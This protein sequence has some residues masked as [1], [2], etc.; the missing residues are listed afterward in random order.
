MGLVAF[1]YTD[2]LTDLASEWWTQPE[3]SYGLL[4][5]PFALYV[6]YLQKDETLALVARP[7][8]SGLLLIAFA[9]IVLITGKLASEFFLTRIS[10]VLLLSGL[11]WTFWGWARF[12]SLAFPLILLLT[13]VPPPVIVYNAAAAPLQLLAS[14][15]AADLAQF[16]GVSIYR[17][18]NIIQL[19]TTSLG[20]AEACSG[21]HSLSALIV[22]SLLLG[23]LEN[24]PL[25]ARIA[26]V[27]LSVPL[28][29]AVNVLRVT[30]TAI[31]ADYR[32]ELALGYYH[33]FSGWLV[34][35]LGFALLWLV[36][37]LIFR[38]GGHPS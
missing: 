20:V 18:G 34:F 32:P 13:M 26:V 28:A 17:D 7:A 4:I 11:V 15:I 1:L 12:R 5:P 8:S 27:V 37:K 3:A 38:F 14:K 6:A 19:A 35:V 16:V 23:F 9:C 29:I 36:S 24:G 31:L 33:A 10:F 22:A 2:I 30:G 25:L 21:L